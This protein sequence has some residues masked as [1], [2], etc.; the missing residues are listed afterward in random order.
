MVAESGPDEGP[1]EDAAAE[2]RR[3]DEPGE[4]PDLLVQHQRSQDRAV[5]EGRELGEDP[6]DRRGVPQS[7]R[8]R[9]VSRQ[10]IFRSR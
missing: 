10:S 2:E 3:E 6:D 4:D 9:K 7:S 5:E 8:A 1:A